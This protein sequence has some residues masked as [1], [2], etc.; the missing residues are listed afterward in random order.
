MPKEQSPRLIV[1]I[2]R[3]QAAGD[4]VGGDAAQ[5]AGENGHGR[6]MHPPPPS[7]E[8]EG[9][10]GGSTSLDGTVPN[11]ALLQ[12]DLAASPGAAGCGS[13]V[14][15][16]GSAS[17]A[18]SVESGL[19]AVGNAEAAAG[20][21]QS[22]IC[23]RPSSPCP[24]LQQQQQPGET[25]PVEAGAISGSSNSGSRCSLDLD[26]VQ[27]PTTQQQQQEAGKPDAPL[28]ECGS[29]G[30]SASE[31]LN[32]IGCGMAADAPHAVLGLPQCVAHG[33]LARLDPDGQRVLRAVSRGLYFEASR[34]VRCLTICHDNL[35]TLV[36]M[37]LH[38]VWR[39]GAPWATVFH[40]GPSH[41]CA[42]RTNAKQIVLWR[43]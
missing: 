36:G 39:G 7:E 15:A 1:I 38:Q 27:G 4:A 35:E 32:D 16:F 21:S 8:E 10:P 28:S 3:P 42:H 20:Q 18:T 40:R 11:V 19:A 9:R 13:L 17:R 41:P 43:D 24:A 31:P 26:P 37:P 12:C 14:V 6:G 25:D 22:G 30:P 2:R 5:A 29:R 23:A 34:H 33:V